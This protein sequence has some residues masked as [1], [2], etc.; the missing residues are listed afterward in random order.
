M[1]S[2]VPIPVL[3]LTVLGYVISKHAP[4][5]GVTD[6]LSQLFG[7]TAGNPFHGDLEKLRSAFLTITLPDSNRELDRAV[8]RSSL[9][10]SLFCLMEALREPMEPA[11][12]TLER[13]NLKIIA[14]VELDDSTHIGSADRKRDAMT[15]AAGYQTNRFQSRQKPS[16]REI[17][18]LFQ[19][20]RGRN[21][22]ACH[23]RG[24]ANTGAQRKER[25]APL[26]GRCARLGSRW[27]GSV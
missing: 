20:A 26:T 22:T 16:E 1:V 21:E 15:K 13:W 11:S 6:L 3:I 19:H 18:A 4:V 10:A 24:T 8:A 23:R 25:A 17:A 2:T 27:I 14:L 9:H 5:G 7:G 12:G